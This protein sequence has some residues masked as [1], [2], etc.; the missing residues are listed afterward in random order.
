M[1]RA[2]SAFS[3]VY[4]L[5]PP[6]KLRA[7]LKIEIECVEPVAEVRLVAVGTVV[8]SLK[9]KVIAVAQLPRPPEEN[10]AAGQLRVAI[11]DVIYR[12]NICAGRNP[13]TVLL[14]VNVPLKGKGVA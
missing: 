4:E 6:W 11:Q 7:F 8:I 13:L 5:L 2:L 12:W 14:S 9:L 10:V 3:T 1:A